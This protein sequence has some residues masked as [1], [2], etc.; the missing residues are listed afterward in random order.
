MRLWAC[1]IEECILLERL[2]YAVVMRPL[3][4]WGVTSLSN[5]IS[6]AKPQGSRTFLAT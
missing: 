4:F 3:R 2:D 5:E 1:W 6:M